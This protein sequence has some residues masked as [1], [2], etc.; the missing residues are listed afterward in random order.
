[1]LS[2][3]PQSLICNDAVMSFLAQGTPIAETIRGCQDFRR[4]VSV[5]T[6]QG[7]AVSSEGEYLGKALRYY[8]AAGIT[9]H[10]IRAD[11]GAQV[12]N[13]EGARACLQLPERM[14][15]DVDFLRYEADALEILRDVGYPITEQASELQSV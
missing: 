5:Q 13:S 3:N 9:S 15:A 6:V 10:F 14:P 11:S 12:S 7:G 2:K 4:F 1:V 8:Y